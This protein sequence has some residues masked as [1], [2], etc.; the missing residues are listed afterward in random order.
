MSKAA[1]KLKFEEAMKR[2]DEIVEAMDSGKIG[3]EESI[4]RY[5]EAMQLASQCRRILTLCEQR[6]RRIQFDADGQPTLTE[7]EPPAGEPD[8]AAGREP[9]GP[10]DELDAGEDRP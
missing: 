1:R 8:D 4:D 5:E 2:L 10:A 3:I 9:S 6:I 7:F